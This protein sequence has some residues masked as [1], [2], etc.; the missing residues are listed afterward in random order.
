MKV[1]F[2]LQMEYI[3]IV[4]NDADQF[5]LSHCVNCLA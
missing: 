2:I 3:F 1:N 5:V 4:R